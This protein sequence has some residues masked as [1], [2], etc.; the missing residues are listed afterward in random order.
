MLYLLDLLELFIPNIAEWIGLIGILILFCGIAE[1]F[2][3]YKL[4]QLVLGVI[5]FLTG[6]AIGVIL[7]LNS[8]NNYNGDTIRI[9]ILV[10][11]I[12]GSILAETFHELGVFIVVGA[13]GGFIVF[14]TTNNKPISLVLGIIFGIAGVVIEQ[15][16]IIVTTA[17][18]GGEMAAMGIWFIGLSNGDNIRVQLLGWIIG[19]CGLMFQLWGTIKPTVKEYSKTIETIALLLL[20]LPIVLCIILGA[21]FR[22]MMFGFGF[23]AILYILLILFYT[24]E[25]SAS[26]T[27]AG[28]TPTYEWEKYIKI[29]IENHEYTVFIA[30]LFP[31]V[32]I[33]GLIMEFINAGLFGLTLAL[34]VFAGIYISLYNALSH[35]KP[36]KQ[37]D[38]AITENTI[39]NM[40]QND[41]VVAENVKGAKADLQING[42]EKINFCSMCGSHLPQGAS[43]C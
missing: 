27:P 30:P 36:K 38:S 12:V 7:F 9:Y 20:G 33:S 29:F 4:F 8:G 5:G 13:M 31:A 32:F 23:V 22:S 6:A 42:Q 41:A 35:K 21:L 37:N 26:V 19:I 39:L 40:Q 17:L 25:L 34:I 14:L 16:A 10:G 2:F 18:S 43:F 15:Y 28:Y 11:G 1:A 3:G 24:R